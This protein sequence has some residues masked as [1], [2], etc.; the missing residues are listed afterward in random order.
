MDY[1][2]LI[3]QIQKNHKLYESEFLRILNT[4]HQSISLPLTTNSNILSLITF[5]STV[6]HFYDSEYPNFLLLHLNS[7]TDFKLKKELINNLF[8][9]KHKKLVDDHLFFKNILL[10][11]DL[12]KI[13]HKVV[14]EIR[15]PRVLISLFSDYLHKGDE[16]Q[17]AFSIY[18]ICYIYEKYRCKECEEIIKNGFFKEQKVQNICILYLLNEI[19]FNKGEK[20]RYLQEVGIHNGKEI[21]KFLFK[22]VKRKKRKQRCT[23]K[24]I[25]VY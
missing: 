23:N 5:L 15:E 16:K 8:I 7:A 21:I 20:S 18:M 3:S 25:R 4:Y 24:K 12:Q 9:I 22:E 19:D 13:L 1:T 17:M 11:C 6:S 2:T 10:H 14:I